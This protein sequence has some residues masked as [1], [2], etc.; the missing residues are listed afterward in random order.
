MTCIVG[1]SKDGRC[2]I[3]GDSAGADS[4]RM[5]IIGRADQKVFQTGAFVMGFT[6]SFRMGQLL[7]Y[8]F[9]APAPRDGVSLMAYMST[10]FVDAVRTCLKAGGFA[11]KESEN[12]VGGTFLVGFRGQLFTI[13]SDYQVEQCLDGFQSVGCGDLIALG[14]LYETKKEEPEKRIL[15]A[16]A[17]AEHFSAG[18]RGPFNVVY[19]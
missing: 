19:A 14:S 18:V 13:Y 4:S 15:K 11:K 7:N 1:I 6:T 8:S 3:G 2:Y 5:Q 9:S 16:L 10:D 12:E 17:A